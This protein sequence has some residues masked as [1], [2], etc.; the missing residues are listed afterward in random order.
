MTTHAQLKYH[1]H[2]GVVMGQVK[3]DKKFSGE[4]HFQSRS[5]QLPM[6]Q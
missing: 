4:H 6:M 5:R 3:K 2:I 1:L